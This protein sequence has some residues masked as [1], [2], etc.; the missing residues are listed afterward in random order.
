MSRKHS[1]CIETLDGKIAIPVGVHFLPGEV[2][3][4]EQ[5]EKSMSAVSCI[6][7]CLSC[8]KDSKMAFQGAVIKGQGHCQSG[9][10]IA[11]A[12][13]KYVPNAQ[14]DTSLSTL[15]YRHAVSASRKTKNA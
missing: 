15:P 11:S 2:S 4:E 12:K 14:E 5:L 13:G 9:C 8:L 6:Q 7:T 3:G 10:E 1:L